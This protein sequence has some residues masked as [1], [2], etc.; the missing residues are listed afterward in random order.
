MGDKHKHPP[1]GRP[2]AEMRIKSKAA[3]CEVCRGRAY[4][5]PAGQNCAGCG[6]RRNANT[7][8]GCGGLPERVEGS[9]CKDCGTPAGKNPEFHYPTL[10]RAVPW[11]L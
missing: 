6:R 3:A 11:D 2:R 5:V 1:L 9:Q 8:P 10:R 7:C 4:Q